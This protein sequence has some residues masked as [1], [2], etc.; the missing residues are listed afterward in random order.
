MSKNLNEFWKSKTTEF[1]HFV[2]ANFDSINQKSVDKAKNSISDVKLML[3]DGLVVS[4]LKETRRGNF[5]LMLPFPSC[6]GINEGEDKKQWN[7]VLLNNKTWG[8]RYAEYINA[9]YDIKISGN[10]VE[11]ID[12]AVVQLIKLYLGECEEEQIVSNLIFLRV[13]SLVGDYMNM[14]KEIT[15]YQEKYKSKEDQDNEWSEVTVVLSFDDLA[16]AAG[17][18]SDAMNDFADLF[19]EVREDRVLPSWDEFDE[20][21]EIDIE[22]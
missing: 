6:M 1:L 5:L 8:M 15:S 4:L 14:C 3:L 17:V 22:F 11:C 9:T 21:W 18:T 7:K 10:M 20:D 2:N 13:E 16:G 12:E 19:I